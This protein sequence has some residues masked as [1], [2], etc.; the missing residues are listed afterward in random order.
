MGAAFLWMIDVRWGVACV[1]FGSV[2]VLLS[3]LSAWNA[4]AWRATEAIW[5]AFAGLE[6]GLLWPRPSAL[7]ALLPALVALWM[8]RAR[9]LV[10]P[11]LEGVPSPDGRERAPTEVPA[12]SPCTV[13][14][15][16]ES[17]VVA[18][19]FCASIGVMSFRWP[20]TFRSL[21]LGHARTA[22][23]LPTLF[24]A[25]FGWWGIPWG[26]LWTA[27]V[28]ELNLTVGGA[29]LD[30][31]VLREMRERE[32]LEGGIE[33]P[34]PMT[35]AAYGLVFGLVSFVVLAAGRQWLPP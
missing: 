17:E 20:G 15:S 12:W 29:L 23:V 16:R 5:L 35:D 34:T 9:R 10:L 32:A 24:T 31:D 4:K 7:V 22:A 28:L 13:C 1:G 33:P 19:L 6:L 27:Q 21:C 14:G 8:L 26:I 3:I 2:F 30:S 25:C 11:R 18:P